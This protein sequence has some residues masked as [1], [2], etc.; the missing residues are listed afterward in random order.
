MKLLKFLHKW[1]SV[2]VGLQL[3]IW[4]GSGL[5][6]SLMDHEKASGNE[7]RKET[8]QA[9]LKDKAHF[10]DLS[11]ILKQEQAQGHQVNSVKLVQLLQQP[12]Y[13]INHQKGLYSHFYNKHTLIN[14]YTGNLKV[15][16]E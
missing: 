7:N 2:I 9:T 10:I 8:V 11:V 16:D 1:L 14:A 4:L 5:F 13:L 3:L 12:Y 6:F 15:I